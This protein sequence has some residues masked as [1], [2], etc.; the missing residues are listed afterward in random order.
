MGEAISYALKNWSALNRY[1]G[2]GF[3]PID[4]NAAERALRCVAVGRKNWEFAGS[5][6][7]GHR[8]AIFYTLV[9]TCKLHGVDPEAYLADVLVR[10][11]TTPQSRIAELFPQSWAKARLAE[12]TA[13][14][15]D[16][17]ALAK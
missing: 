8:A 15:A 7:G 5:D 13:A 9:A 16:V 12:A 10:V 11:A 17:A 14:V 6:D 4:N 1:T 3:L 2:H